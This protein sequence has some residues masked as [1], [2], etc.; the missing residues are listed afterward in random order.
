MTGIGL[1]GNKV[2]KL[3]TRMAVS[4]NPNRIDGLMSMA[5]DTVDFGTPT[6][7]CQRSTLIAN[8]F[9]TTPPWRL[10]GIVICSPKCAETPGNHRH[11]F[12]S[13]QTRLAYEASRKV[14]TMT[15]WKNETKPVC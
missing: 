3:S 8:I 10:S 5:K 12:L 2:V 11:D 4:I 14:G 1:K 6:E 9:L 13:R 15:I 7:D